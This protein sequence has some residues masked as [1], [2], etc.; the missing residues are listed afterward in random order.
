MLVSIDIRRQRRPLRRQLRVRPDVEVALGERVAKA[1]DWTG[2]AVMVR[3]ARA[4][5]LCNSVAEGSCRKQELVEVQ[6]RRQGLGGVVS[7][8]Q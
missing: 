5:R 4:E 3:E 6:Q 7:A 1:Q 2:S 8:R